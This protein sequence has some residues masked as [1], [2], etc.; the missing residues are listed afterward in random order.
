MA[1]RPL[2]GYC[3]LS[4]FDLGVK[5]EIRENIR[6]ACIKANSPKREAKN[7]SNGTLAINGVSLHS[8]VS[9]LALN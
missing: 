6:M 2:F 3:L 4:L 5:R 9:R 7:H 8:A 1:A